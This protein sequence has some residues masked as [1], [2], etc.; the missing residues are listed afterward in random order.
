MVCGT[1]SSEH[2][3]VKASVPFFLYVQVHRY[4]YVIHAIYERIYVFI[5]ADLPV[6]VHVCVSANVPIPMCNIKIY[7][8]CLSI[9]VEEYEFI[10]KLPRKLEN[11]FVK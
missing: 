1:V 6:C 8:F 9:Y 4:M 5:V 2:C 7:V 11:I 10:R 3:V